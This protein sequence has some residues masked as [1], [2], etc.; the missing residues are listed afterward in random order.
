M[1]TQDVKV[2]LMNKNRAL[3]IEFEAS[4]TVDEWT[5]IKDSINSLA[6]GE[7]LAGQ[8]I[9]AYIGYYTAGSGMLRIR[10]SQ[11]GGVVKLLGGLHMIKGQKPVPHRPIRIGPDD[12]IEVFT[13][14]AGS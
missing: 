3:A 4:A 12:V 8:V 9:D 11:S 5:E 14:V 13:T 10:N 1:T 6:L 2:T 7:V